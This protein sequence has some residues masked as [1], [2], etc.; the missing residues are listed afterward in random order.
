M[1][2]CLVVV[3]YQ[4]DFVNGSLGCDAALELDLRIAEKIKR[5]HDS[6]DDVLFTLDT[7][8]KDYLSTQE[9]KKLPVEHCIEGTEGREIFGQTGKQIRDQ[10]R[11]F[12]KPSFG[13]GELYEYFT[14]HSYHSIEFVGVVSNICVISNVILAKTAQPETEIIVDASCVAS[15]DERLNE[16]AL[17][18]MESIQVTVT[19]RGC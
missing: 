13:S 11:L 10:D 17:D 7:H 9:G 14:K 2:K 4:N 16:A 15:N 1:K 3:D 5:Y 6:G 8:G 19:R 18:V 12:S